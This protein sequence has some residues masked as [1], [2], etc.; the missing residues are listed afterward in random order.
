MVKDPGGRKFRA[1]ANIYYILGLEERWVGVGSVCVYQW[2][3]EQQEGGKAGSSSWVEALE[4]KGKGLVTVLK[5]NGG[6]WK[7]AA[8]SV[9]LGSHEGNQELIY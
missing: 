9:I 1:V 5:R 2:S 8:G 3:R 6:T 7:R 4:D